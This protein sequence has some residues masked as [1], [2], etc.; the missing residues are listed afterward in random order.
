M[1]WGY[2]NSFTIEHIDGLKRKISCKDCKYYMSDDKSCSKRPLY[3]P[4][5]GYNSWRGCK[6]FEL[7]EN[8]T[9]IDE[10]KAQL[11]RVKN[12][13]STKADK[14]GKLKSAVIGFK[15]GDKISHTKFGIGEIVS[16]KNNMVTVK[17]V[18][19]NGKRKSVHTM[20]KTLDL[21]ICVKNSLISKV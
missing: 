21:R 11:L 8:A 14:P 18:I 7:D 10:K 17:F 13:K 19:G 1:A 4:E 12:S 3:L 5:D 16:K 15:V 20:E 6:F 9:H 2:E